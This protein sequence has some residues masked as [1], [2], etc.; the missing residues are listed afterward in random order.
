MATVLDLPKVKEKKLPV[1]VFA[2]KWDLREGDGTSDV[3]GKKAK[4]LTLGEFLVVPTH[5]H[6]LLHLN[7]SNT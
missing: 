1:L 2:T 6:T 4:C 7:Y 5:T 3:G